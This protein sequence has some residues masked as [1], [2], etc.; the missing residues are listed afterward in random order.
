[1]AIIG[2]LMSQSMDRSRAQIPILGDIPLLGFFFGKRGRVQEKR[3][4]VVIIT[5]HIVKSGD[6]LDEL[7]ARYRDE[8]DLQRVEMRKDMNFWRRVFKKEKR[9]EKT[10]RTGR[11][12]RAEGV[13]ADRVLGRKFNW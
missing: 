10:T 1:M 8:Y 5:P 6:D 2:G 13:H 3:N 7:T 9:T 11:T 12:G 4:L